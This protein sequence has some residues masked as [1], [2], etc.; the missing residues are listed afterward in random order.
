DFRPALVVDQVADHGGGR[1]TEVRK[2]RQLLAD[3]IEGHSVDELAS[4]LVPWPHRVQKE[5]ALAAAVGI[6]AGGAEGALRYVGVCVAN[7][8]LVFLLP[9]GP[10]PV[11]VAME[12]EEERVADGDSRV[13]H[14]A[15]GPDVR[16]AVG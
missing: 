3:E 14:P 9:G 11:D 12:Q 7:V 5:M 1:W 10:E 4:A 2:A 15:I 6:R 13:A 16:I 8:V